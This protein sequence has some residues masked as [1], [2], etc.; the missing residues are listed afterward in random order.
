M[1]SNMDMGWVFWVAIA[2]LSMYSQYKKAK[3][4]E[5]KR[6]QE[7]DSKPADRYEAP[8]PTATGGDFENVDPGKLLRELLGEKPTPPKPKQKTKPVVV[9]PQVE[10]VEAARKPLVFQDPSNP[11]AVTTT[12]T[13]MKEFIQES[14]ITDM[15][16]SNEKQNEAVRNF[17]LRNA[18]LS[19]IIL[20]RPEY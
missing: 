12:A 19:Q 14:A 15:E 20:E 13:P 5:L 6:K 18:V 2:V 11:Y 10:P 1:I 17:D 16:L 4:A 8:R 7:L 9:K 3:K